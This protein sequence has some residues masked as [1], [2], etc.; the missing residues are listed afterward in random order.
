MKKLIVFFAGLFLSSFFFTSCS[1]KA[2]ILYKVKEDSTGSI[3]HIEAWNMNRETYYDVGESIYYCIGGLDA[4]VR[5][6]E[7][8][9]IRIDTL[10]GKPIKVVYTGIGGLQ[11]VHHGVIISKIDLEKK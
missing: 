9:D 5:I 10:N 8:H 6:Y 11:P 7:S 3:S 1:P 2:D 4:S